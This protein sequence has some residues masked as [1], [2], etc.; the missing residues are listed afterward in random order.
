MT[1][2]PSPSPSALAHSTKLGKLI[3]AE[4][5]ASHGWISF[6]HFM[7]L[8]LYAPGLGYYSAGLQ[9]F[10]EQGDF[11]T[12]PE[13][14]SLF[15]RCLAK[16]AAQILCATGGDILEL[17]AGSGKL[18][19]DM[20]IQLD[21]LQCQP[22]HY[23]IL[24]PSASL[25]QTQQKTVTTELP[26]HLAH[27]VAWLDALPKQLT[28]LVIANEVL[29]ALPVHLV[30]HTRE[31]AGTLYELGI[32]VEHQ[33]FVWRDMPLS[34]GALFDAATALRLPEGYLT[35]INL[36]APA[37]VASLAEV[38]DSGAILLLDYGFPQREYYHPQREHG[39]LMCHYRHHAHSDPLLYPGLQDIT[40][41][42]DFTAIA[43]AGRERGLAVLGYA[44]QAQFLISCGITGLLAE[45]SP[46]DIPNYILQVAAVQKLLSPA[47]MGEL[48]KVMVLGKHMDMALLGFVEGDQ[49]Y[50]L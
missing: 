48:F 11:V 3:S 17:G 15:G 16:Q 20:L 30:T 27:K 12:A 1:S 28:G 43:I 37:L 23:F 10:G 14:S 8:A 24:E 26:P 46:E 50:K 7:H 36:A 47:E 44:T 5:Q 2:L 22:E 39:T 13:I 38:L 40:A 29:D 6:E 9:K 49:R 35:E 42:V 4:V 45:T 33:Q 19:V 25:R 41:H 34:Q 18:A 32:S 21:V 31:D